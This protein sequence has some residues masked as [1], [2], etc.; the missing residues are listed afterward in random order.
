MVSQL[1]GK[2]NQPSPSMLQCYASI[3]V[4]RTNAKDI[5]FLNAISCFVQVISLKS[6]TEM[7]FSSSKLMEIAKIARKS[8]RTIYIYIYI[9]DCGS[10]KR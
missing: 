1:P 6:L 2:T 4:E 5:A 3:Q 8:K 9:H 7:S 10:K